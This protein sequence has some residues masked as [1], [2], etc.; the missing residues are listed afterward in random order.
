MRL[1]QKD[2]GPPA[3]YNVVEAQWS[4]GRLLDL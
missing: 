2:K 3:I 4:S 1:S